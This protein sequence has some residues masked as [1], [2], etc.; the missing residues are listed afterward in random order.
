M[1]S[2][3]VY[4]RIREKIVRNDLRPGTKI[5][6][7]ALVRELGVSQTPVREALHHLEGDGL[8][9]RVK[10]RGYSTTALL[11][12]VEFRHMFEVRMLLEPWSARVLS[13][14]RMTNPG[15]D[16]VRQVDDFRASGQVSRTH[17]AMHDELFHKTI[18]QAT[19][20]SFLFAAF[21]SL[22]AQLHLFRLYGDDIE[23]SRTLGEHFDVTLDEHRDIARAVAECRPDDAE[24]AMR[25]HLEN[26][27]Q[28]FAPQ[29][30]GGAAPG[31]TVA[32][33]PTGRIRG[34]L[35]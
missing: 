5:N 6:I 8:V 26:S 9:E 29:M 7:D 1:E 31:T 30:S 2:R 32:G 33:V 10:G 15:D 19:G 12:G 35:L 24:A 13:S 22:H 3:S 28:R 11:D 21:E 18:Q 34:R 4:D 23:G 20:N 27:L 25:L 16:L 14:D 17:L